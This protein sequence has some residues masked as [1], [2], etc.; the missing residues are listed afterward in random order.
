M[1]TNAISNVGDVDGVDISAH[2][3]S[4]AG[5]GGT[6]DYT[7]VTNSV[8]AALNLTD[9]YIL[10][11]DGGDRGAQTSLVSLNDSGFISTPGEISGYGLNVYNPTG[12]GPNALVFYT[13]GSALN[14]KFWMWVT[15]G[16]TLHLRMQ[17]DVFGTPTEVMSFSRSGATLTGIT[18]HGPTDMDANNITN[19][20]TVDG[21][22]IST[23]DHSGAG[24]GGT[25]ALASLGVGTLAEL[26]SK[27]SDATL[28]EPPLTTKGDLYTFSTTMDRLGVGTNGQVLTADSA[29]ATGLKW[30]TPATAPVTSVFGRIGDVI[31]ASGDY[32][33]T[34]VTDAVGAASIIG[35]DAIVVGAGGARGTEGHA[36]VT[37]NAAAD[38]AAIR[39]AQFNTSPGTVNHSDGLLFWDEAQY[40]PAYYN[41]RTA[42]KHQLGRELWV[43]VKNDT[44]GPLSN[45]DI[46][47]VT[48][49]NTDKP[50]VDQASNTDKG[51]TES[52]IAVLTEN[53]EDGASGEATRFGA[54]NDIN[55]LGETSGDA[56]YLGVDGA[57]T[58][59]RPVPPN[60]EVRVG[61]IGYVNASTGSLNI[62]IVGFNETDTNV[63]WEGALNGV[64][65]QTQGVSFV[66]SGGVI[67]A[68][69]V[70]EEAPTTKLPVILDSDRYLL[71]TLTGSGAGG[72][73]RVALTAG[74]ATNPQINFLYINLVGSV[75][76]L[77]ASTTWPFGTAA[78]IGLV[79]VK[80]AAITNI[81]G[82]LGFQRFNN[83]TNDGGG[84]GI[85]N[86]IL[87]RIRIFGASW[88]SGVDPTVTITVNPGSED[89]VNITTSSGLAWQFHNQTMDATDGSEYYVINHPT[90]GVHKITDLNEIDVY[91]DGTSIGNEDIIGLNMFGLQSSSGGVDR[92]G[93]MLPDG[94]YT[95]TG[96]SA[97]ALQFAID[98]A[99][100]DANNYA[101]TSITSGIGLNSITF[102]ICRLVLRYTTAA[103]GTWENVVT[104]ETGD[105]FQDE[106]GL[107]QGAIS[108]GGGGS[109]LIT[110]FSDVD[111]DIY[112]NA[113]PT[114]VFKVEVGG[115]TTG[116]TRT[117]TVPDK[118]FT[119]GLDDNAIHDNVAAEINVITEKTVL[120][121]TDLFLIEDSEDS[122]NKKKVQ[123]TN[124][125]SAG[126]S[127]GETWTFDSGTTDADPGS[128]KF[129]F[130]NATQS[131]A[132]YIYVNKTAESG[133][134]MGTILLL[135]TT[136]HRI[137]IQRDA[138]STRF[139]LVQVTGAAIDA[140]TYVKIPI[141]VTDS[142]TD[143]DTKRCGWI[144]L[145]SGAA[146][147]H[148][149]TH[150][151]GGSDEIN[152][153]SLSGVL[154]DP[155]TAI[156]HALDNTARHSALSD[157]TNFNATASAHGFLP[158]LSGAVTD[159][160]NGSGGWSEPNYVSSVS[161]GDGMNFSVITSSGSV[162]LGLPGTL[163]G[164]TVNE[165][166]AGS[167]KHTIST[168]VEHTNLLSVDQSAGG[169]PVSGDYAR[170][171]AS[172]LEGRSVIEARGDLDVYQTTQLYTQTEIDTWR[173]GVTQTEMGYLD[174]VTSDIQTQLN[175]K[176]PIANPTFT[177]EIGIGAVNVSETE[178]GILEGA[179]LT[180][181]ELNFVDGVT[182][183]I[184]TQ[185][186]TKVSA[187]SAFTAANRLLKSA[188]AD[189]TS[190]DSGITVDSSDRM[191]GVK[192][193]VSD[194]VYQ[195]TPNP[196]TGTAVTIDLANGQYQKIN[197]ANA[198]AATA[199]ITASSTTLPG[200]GT[201]TVDIVQD[202]TGSRNISTWAVSGSISTKRKIGDLTI[203]GT[204]SS[205]TELIIKWDG[206]SEVILQA[207]T[208]A[209]T[210]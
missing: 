45:G 187:A 6:I 176:A 119:F 57:W 74:T 169:G 39:T 156:Q 199:T 90:L 128:K 132:T 64:A 175:A 110:S 196:I 61:S 113:D 143:L 50:T 162:T 44:G 16:S 205:I 117:A 154:A 70:N 103:S 111:F 38:L 75:P 168:G 149:T 210:F 192:T 163:T 11:G 42:V 43:R 84:Q 8:G 130:N 5:Q 189:R 76:T 54:V 23:H 12:T 174:G 209:V 87:Q 71:D 1:D 28:Y 30:D 33:Y 27:L 160:L 10:R 146:A 35:E 165:V 47:Y 52:V 22:D 72:A 73:A 97:A 145:F 173:N 140:T 109:S 3:H 171:T 26:N 134:D 159:F 148:A 151:N 153:G 194:S 21:V 31:A 157:N 85:I 81:D 25:V 59:T 95:P 41:D 144:M 202:V 98:Q 108:G 80:T 188:G 204:G 121:S 135:L 131:S 102:R 48:G 92:I 40:C 127:L 17:T 197:L 14:E 193:L 63:N 142:G 104:E 181:T 112:D 172:G 4:G 89:N 34:E 37:L 150:Q 184:Q 178:L 185:L 107:P 18:L 177:G 200:P 66:V 179:T 170:F 161:A 79:S 56:V 183:A 203:D 129:R 167:H 29:E 198:S 36:L 78:I 51:E 55:T 77:Q 186:N 20:G 94:V 53:I 83:A 105:D 136:G 82:V 86:E 15:L 201:W 138:D 67:Y 100:A 13:G 7:N 191:S 99:L 152:V 91:A 180:T 9:N 139:H 182:S 208:K 62:D 158:K 2:D 126:A 147:L 137:Y 141:T 206:V 58:T 68:D 120:A 49:W 133:V 123:V 195:I 69:V 166:T 101:I 125:P 96:P 118:N 122:N 155:Q 116:T 88:N 32:D 164:A 124:I 60:Y 114:K 24:Q 207:S 19:V 115:V 93:I 46:V 65:P 190:D 106:R